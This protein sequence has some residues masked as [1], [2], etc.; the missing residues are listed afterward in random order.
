MNKRRLDKVAKRDRTRVLMNKIVMPLLVAIAAISLSLLL[1]QLCGR[2]YAD[3]LN[4]EV[5]KIQVETDGTLHLDMPGETE[6]IYILWETDGGSIAPVSENENLK[7][8]Y[9]EENLGYQL[10]A[11]CDE[12]VVWSPEDAD[13]SRYTTATIAATVYI[14]SEEEGISCYFIDYTIHQTAAT[15]TYKNGTVTK[16]ETDR[17]FSNPI[18]EE[19]GSDWAQIYAIKTEDD[20]VVYRYRVGY[21]LSESTSLA[22]C[23]ESSDAVLYETDY[24]AGLYPSIN[25]SQEA[26]AKSLLSGV[27]AVTVYK[28]DMEYGNTT[29]NAYMQENGNSEKL[30]IAEKK[31]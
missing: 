11:Q 7:E 26:E 20:K 23:F 22:V 25:I 31:G 18:R 13:G 10:Y 4:R 3:M 21:D 6:N 8:Q 14:K 19:G 1:I 17:Y 27:Q 15:I 29:I 16:E 9:C 24:L 12:K 5:P 30:Y 28:K 2:L